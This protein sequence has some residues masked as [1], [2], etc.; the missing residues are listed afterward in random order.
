[1]RPCC[2]GWL[3]SWTSVS[4]DFGYSRR[5]DNRFGSL[6]LL[7]VATISG[8]LI[9]TQCPGAKTDQVISSHVLVSCCFERLYA[10]MDRL[11]ASRRL[12]RNTG[13]AKRGHL[14]CAQS[15]PGTCCNPDPR[16]SRMRIG[17]R[18]R[19]AA[20]PQTTASKAGHIPPASSPGERALRSVPIRLRSVFRSP[21]EHPEN[22]PLTGKQNVS[23]ACGLW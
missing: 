7:H 22:P 14:C 23:L 16:T 11:S 8:L 5:D 3:G 4:S 12:G 10:R 21:I 6:R 17:Q 15:D 9:A 2:A 18:T 19:P 13:A 20:F 1:M